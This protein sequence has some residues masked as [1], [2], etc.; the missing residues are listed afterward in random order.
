MNREMN[1]EM[2]T[3]PEVVNTE[4]IMKHLGKSRAT[5]TRLLKPYKRLMISTD[6]TC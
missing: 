3:L 2:N 6:P 5:I 4:D 1:R